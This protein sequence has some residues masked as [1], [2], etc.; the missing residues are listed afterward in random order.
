MRK[1]SQLLILFLFTVSLT[2]TTAA[3]QE[4][5][6]KEIMAKSLETGKFAELELVSV[7]KT[8]DKKGHEKTGKVRILSK[9]SAKEKLDK[10]RISIIE[11]EEMKGTHIL[12]FDYTDKTDEMWVY[13][14]AIKEPRQIVSNK[15]TKSF[16][17]S[18]FTLGDM[19]V[20]GVSDFNFKLLKSEKVD[21]ADCWVIEC[22]P[23]N[24]NVQNR[25]NYS[26]EILY[27]DK[28]HYITRKGEFY[29]KKGKL[30]KLLNVSDIKKIDPSTNAWMALHMTIENVQ[31]SRKSE[32]TMED[33]NVH[34]NL[35]DELF[36]VESL[37]N[38]EK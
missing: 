22:I 19:S 14:P 20:P 28:S 1:H 9:S 32:I 34:P 8:T 36:T 2:F 38:I 30:V 16:M 12:I 6:A 31:T 23:V 33:I 37:K 25:I 27:I 17:G 35:S 10:R 5:S 26:K 13:M 11:P 24:K 3:Q 21:G 18:E 7:F 29:D 15:M 4:I